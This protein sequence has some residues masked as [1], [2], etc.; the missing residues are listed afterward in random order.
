V[1]DRNTAA[2]I[3]SGGH[4]NAAA[5][6]AAPARLTGRHILIVEDE[7]LIALSLADMVAALGC[8]SVMASRVTKAVQLATTQAFD[9]AILDMNLAGEPGYPIAEALNRRGIPFIIATGYGAEGL[10]ADYRDRPM[11]PKPYLPEH[12][13]T[14]LLKAL[15]LSRS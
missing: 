3:G 6:K 8:T 13:E 15:G 5:S 2:V 14:A 12:V 11:L 9:V 10:K 1:R 7:M 4:M